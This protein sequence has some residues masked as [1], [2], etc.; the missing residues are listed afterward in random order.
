MSLK[1]NGATS[2]SIDIDVPATV[3]G[4][5][6]SLTL[7]GA[8]TVDRLERAGNILQVVEGS[9][10]TE[11]TVSST[12]FTDTGLSASITPTSSSSKILVLVNQACQ[13]KIS[14]GNQGGGIHILRDSTTIHTSLSDSVG[15]F[16][17]YHNN[18]NS[19]V[20]RTV[21]TK[22]D[23]PNTTSSVTYKTQGRPYTTSSSGLMKFQNAG[24]STNATS[25]ITLIEVAG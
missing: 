12:T 17:I 15:P 24:A 3:T 10:S 2:G 1:L 13:T 18:V 19:I 5:D 14:S 9:T 20:Q 16:D 11:V 25:Y 8:G 7:P 21:I 23:S 4:G 22:L 6:V